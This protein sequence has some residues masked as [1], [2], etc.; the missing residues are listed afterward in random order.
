MDGTSGL[1]GWRAC[2]EVVAELSD[3]NDDLDAQ[4][5]PLSISLSD[6]G[7]VYFFADKS[8]RWRVLWPA[9][10]GLTADGEYLLAGTNAT[11]CREDNC[12]G[13]QKRS[14]REHF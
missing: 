7:H 14:R 3:T 8:R 13:Q 4:T 5:L 1:E 10:L 9:L 2:R 12:Y 6:I 11:V